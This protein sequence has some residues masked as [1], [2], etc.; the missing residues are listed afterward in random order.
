MGR[1]LLSGLPHERIDPILDASPLTQRTP[2]TLTDKAQIKQAIAQM[3]EQGW[4]IVDQELEA[5]LISMSAPIR[6]RQQRIIA[7]MNIS[8]NA[9][10]QSA[11]QMTQSCL[12]PLLD[13]AQGVSELIARRG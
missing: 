4:S 10:R 1:V 7:A 11:I 3:R 6:D 5:G 12:A 8:G 2:R 9:Q 13:A